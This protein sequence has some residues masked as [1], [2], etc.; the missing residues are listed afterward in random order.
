[1]LG[2]T[3]EN[4]CFIQLPKRKGATMT[5]DLKE[6]LQAQNTVNAM[7]FDLLAQRD[8]VKSFDFDR[9]TA[10]LIGKLH[11]PGTR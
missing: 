5:N 11:L 7:V 6:F 1:V 8:T 10:L 9:E 2:T 4:K 3:G